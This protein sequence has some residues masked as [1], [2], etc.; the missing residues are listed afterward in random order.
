MHSI[1]IAER[2]LA[3]VTSRDRAASIAGDLTEEAAARGAVWF[4][5]GVIRTAASLLWREVADNP[6]RVCGVA[7]V[8]FAGY[9]VLDLLFAGLS[10]VAFFVV[11]YR[12]GHSFQLSSLP[13]RIWFLA[14]VLLIPLATGRMLAR[15]APGRE[16]AVC[17]GYAIAALAFGC[18]SMMVAPGSIGFLSDAPQILVLAGAAW[19]RHRRLGRGACS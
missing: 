19:G 10:G 14:P 11:A 13:W 4:W 3:V 16:A 5:S 17:L 7:L 1:H 18:V 12:S 15:F 2:I 8:G 9:I 6:V